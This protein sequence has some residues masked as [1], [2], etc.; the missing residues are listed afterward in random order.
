MRVIGTN[1]LV[2]LGFEM[3]IAIQVFSM[4]VPLKKKKKIGLRN[5][6]GLLANTQADMSNIVERYFSDIFHTCHPQTN[7]QVVNNV[8]SKDKDHTGHEHIIIATLYQC[9]NS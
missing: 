5:A 9:R 8:E 6:T 4:Q 1:A 2:S 7:N 3:A